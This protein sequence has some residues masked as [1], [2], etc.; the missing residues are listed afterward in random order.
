MTEKLPSVPVVCIHADAQGISHLLDLELPALAQTVDAEGKTHFLGANGATIMGF[1]VG[2]GAGN[3]D[4]H[5]SGHVGL[6]IV[7][8]GEWE[9][10]AGSGDRRVLGTGSVLLMLDT[11]GQGHRAHYRGTPCTVLG[12]GADDATAAGYRAL[13]AQAL[14]A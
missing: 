11:V 12:V 3:K 9:I 5:V 7:L 14:A 1:V 6:S 2:D 10:E 4:W 13:A 8:T